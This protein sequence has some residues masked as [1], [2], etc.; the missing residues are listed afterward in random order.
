M[1]EN[2]GKKGFNWKKLLTVLVAVGGAVVAAIGEE[3]K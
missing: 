1:E 2:E 3:K